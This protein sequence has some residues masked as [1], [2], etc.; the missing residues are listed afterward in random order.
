M[1]SSITYDQKVTTFCTCG[2]TELPLFHL[3]VLDVNLGLWW[4]QCI[5]CCCEFLNRRH[6][7]KTMG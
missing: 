7:D 1:V 3:S 2:S 4:L 5:I 6:R